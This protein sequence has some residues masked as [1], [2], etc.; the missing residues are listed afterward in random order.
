MSTTSVL[1]PV[2]VA[3]AHPVRELQARKSNTCGVTP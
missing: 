1:C 3:K 2:Y